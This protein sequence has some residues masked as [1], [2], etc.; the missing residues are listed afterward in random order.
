[1]GE[2]RRPATL[3]IE[4]ATAVI[5]A[6]LYTTTPDDMRRARLW[7]W[8]TTQRAARAAGRVYGRGGM[9]AELAG[10]ARQ[11]AQSYRV[12]RRLAALSIAAE[13]R[14]RRSVGQ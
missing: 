14:Y 10:D 9:A 13:A 6:V 11:A 5:V 4:L 12:A 1:M 2:P 7:A 3:L 8:R